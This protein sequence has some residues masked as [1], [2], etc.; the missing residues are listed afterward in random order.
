L[1]LAVAGNATH[2]VT[3]DQD[4]LVLNPFKGI[5]IVAPGGFV[6]GR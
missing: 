4:L 6:E 1:S 2:I 3:G 5:H